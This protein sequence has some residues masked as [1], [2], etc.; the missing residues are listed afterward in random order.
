MP[1]EQTNDVSPIRQEIDRLR[2]SDALKSPLHPSHPQALKTLADLYSAEFPEE[3]SEAP[4]AEEVEDLKAEAKSVEEEA[5]KVDDPEAAKVQEAL[6]PLRDEWGSAY[7]SNLTT[8]QGLVEHLGR[9]MG[10]D[11]VEVFD[12]IGSHPAVIKACFEWSQGRDGGE[13]PAE[14]AKEI[15]ALIQ[16][17]HV[18]Q[19]GISQTSE[20]LRNVMQALY[21]VTYR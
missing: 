1:D 5:L 21:A 8:A 19:A 7:E 20:V 15:I 11:A 14:T 6:Q 17:S 16:K 10:L 4:S 9:E 13:I 12:H 3:G 2:A 18:Y